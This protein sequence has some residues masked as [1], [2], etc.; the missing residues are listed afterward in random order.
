[1]RKIIH[2]IGESNINRL[3][4]YVTK[5]INEPEYYVFKYDL[6]KTAT[7]IQT[8]DITL[9]GRR[10]YSYGG[11][12]KRI[13]NHLRT[14]DQFEDLNDD[15]NANLSRIGNRKSYF[16]STCGSHL[17][18]EEYIWFPNSKDFLTYTA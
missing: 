16:C 3:A 4:W 12:L 17:D 10:V 2:N 8:L 9:F 15:K 1:V 5:P 13:W 11:E 6:S 18:K 7:T 14:I